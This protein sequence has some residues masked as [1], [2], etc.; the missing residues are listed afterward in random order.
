VPGRTYRVLRSAT[1]DGVPTVSG[2]GALE[3]SFEDAASGPVGFYR[4]VAP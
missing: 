2:E 1:L 4:I 3:G